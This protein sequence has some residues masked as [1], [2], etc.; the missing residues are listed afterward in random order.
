VGEIPHQKAL[1]ERHKDEP[2]A[3]VGVNTDSD[4]D[5]YEKKVA[6][7]GVTWRSSW[8]GGMDGPVPTTWGVDSYPTIFVLDADHVIRY[9]DA[10]GPQLGR[11]V[12]ELLAELEAGKKAASP[13]EGG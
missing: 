4:K 12:E 3:I 8:Q 1:V 2:F 7:Y 5:D 6:E 10:R 11:V 13:P 9:L